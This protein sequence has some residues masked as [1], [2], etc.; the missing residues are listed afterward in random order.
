[1][2]DLVNEEVGAVVTFDRYSSPPNIQA[3]LW[4]G[5]RLDVRECLDV[6]VTG[7]GDLRYNLQAAESLVALDYH[8]GRQAWTLSAIDT[9]A[10]FY[11]T[12]GVDLSWIRGIG[13]MRGEEH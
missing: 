8:S 3:I 1:M 5:R 12:A 9:S 7:G 11:P 10:R 4:Q 2:W 6:A 13:E